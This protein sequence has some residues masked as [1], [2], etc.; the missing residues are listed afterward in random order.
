MPIDKKQKKEL[1][2]LLHEIVKIRDGGKCL[3]CGK[4]GFQLSHIYPKGRYKRMELEPDNIKALCFACHLGWWHK[5]PIEAH[6]W[7]ETAIPKERLNRL[8][9]MSMTQFKAPLDFKLLKLSLEQMLRKLEKR[10]P[11]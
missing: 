11:I 8:R 9:L 7:L 5:N 3:K 1:Y 4:A 2:A 6:E 10:K